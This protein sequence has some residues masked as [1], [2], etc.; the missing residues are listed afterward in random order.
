MRDPR[1]PQGTLVLCECSRVE[2][3]LSCTVGVGS[4]PRVGWRCGS[5]QHRIL[6]GLLPAWEEG[7]WPQPC[8]IKL[9]LFLSVCCLVW[10]LRENQSS[11]LLWGVWGELVR[12]GGV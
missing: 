3:T 2:R 12:L 9:V 8:H 7:P 6:R 10:R 5:C 1:G 11:L 4:P